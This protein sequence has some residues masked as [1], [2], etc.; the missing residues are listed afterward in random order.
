[1]KIKLFR[2]IYKVAT[3]LMKWQYNKGISGRQAIANCYTSRR[4]KNS[5]I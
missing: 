1:M 5:K 4:W 2:M 3:I